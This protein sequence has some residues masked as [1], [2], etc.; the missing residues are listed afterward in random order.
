MAQTQL[1]VLAVGDVVTDAFIKLLDDEAKVEKTDDGPRLSMAF[2]TKVPFDH[3]EVIPAVGNAANAAVA[4]AKLGL[5][6]G[7][8]ANVGSDMWG[9]EIIA[10]LEKAQVD[11]RFVH[12]NPGHNSNYHYVLWYKEERTILIKHEEYEYHWPRF[13]VID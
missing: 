1:D 4:F 2:G 8:V 6:S 13:R 10:G 5:S 3:A 9:R 7:L 12:I 11:S